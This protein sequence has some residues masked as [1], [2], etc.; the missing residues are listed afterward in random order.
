[1]TLR[2]LGDR[3]ADPGWSS[4][5]TA[6][7]RVVAAAGPRPSRLG[8]HVWA[9]PVEGLSGVAAV[10]ASGDPGDARPFFGHLTLARSK[11]RDGLRGL[12]APEISWRWEVDEV[13]L[14]ASMLTSDGARYTILERWGLRGR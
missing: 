7:P 4:L 6:T 2:F 11:R 3:P 10:F 1:V 14:V 5:L 8:L 13:T 12:P 9:L